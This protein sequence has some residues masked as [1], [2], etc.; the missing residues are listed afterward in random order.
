VQQPARAAVLASEPD[1]R[2]EFATVPEVPGVEF[3]RIDA[4]ARLW[5]WHHETYTVS[6]P[7]VP[8]HVEWRYRTQLHRTDP[9][10]IALM[11]PGEMSAELRKDD[12]YD[13]QRV[14]FFSPEAVNAA[15][16]ELG[17]PGGEVHW[18]DGQVSCANLHGELLRAHA[19]FETE[20]TTLE[21]QSRIAHVL[22]RLLTECSESRTLDPPPTLESDA[23]RKARAFLLDHWADN[24]SLEDLV[25]VVGIGRFRLVRAFHAAVGLPP[26]AYQIRVRVGRAMAMIRM[27]SPLVEVATTTGFADQS[28]LARHFTRIVGIAPGRYRQAVR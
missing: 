28:H 7:P 26:H 21:R 6:S 18:R 25:G 9:A 17:R 4:V 5:R 20:T 11:E 8:I 3:F 27:G 22:E 24:V 2:I 19:A 23:V 14:L 13:Q 12:R 15:A 10:A 16:R 1:D